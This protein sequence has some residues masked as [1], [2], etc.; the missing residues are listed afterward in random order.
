MNVIVT[1]GLMGHNNPPVEIEPTPFEMSEVEIGD[2]YAEA[3]NWLDGEPV[4]SQA[5]AD[6]L[7]KLIDDLRK[8]AKLAD[9]RRVAENKPFD[10]GKA[11]VQARY[12]PLIADTKSVKGKAVLA[13]DMA[14]QALAPWLQKLEAEKQAAAAKA[15]A[16]ADEKLRI[17]QDALRASQVADLD[18]REAAEA[19]IREA[20]KAEAT[21]TKAEGAK[22]HAT[23]GSRAMG[24]RS[25]WRAEM[26]DG[27]A[28]AAHYW[29]TRRRDV[30]AFFQGLADADVRAGKREIPGFN[31]IEDRV[32]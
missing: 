30:D 15:R 17:A 18:K 14:K 32:L 23:G 20:E 22:A 16:E 1:S 29:T 24:L 25:V 27:R 6:G 9:E 5:Q 31:I 28:A 21:A 11:E 3:K 4:T 19:L 12:A 26:T 13:I 7:S 10:D 2:L 8:S